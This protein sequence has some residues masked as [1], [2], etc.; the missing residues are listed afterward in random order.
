MSDRPPIQ[1]K[2]LVASSGVEDEVCGS[3]AEIGESG[4]RVLDD[5]FDSL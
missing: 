5:A 3:K 1:I 4:G 2:V